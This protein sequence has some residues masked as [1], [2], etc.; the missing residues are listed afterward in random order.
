[1]SAADANEDKATRKRRREDP[2]VVQTRELVY[3][4]TVEVIAEVGAAGISVD[5]IAE[6]SGVARSTIYRHWP[7]QSKLYLEA[8]AVL[9]RRDAVPLTGE[10]RTDLENYLVEY[11]SRL[12]DRTYISVLI[13]LLDRV[14]RD[15]EFAELYRAIFDERRSRAASIFRNGVRKGEFRKGIDIAEAVVAFLAPFTY[16][17]IVRHEQI[18]PRHVQRV[19][20]DLFERFG[21]AE[22]S[23]SPKPPKPKRARAAAA[24]AT[25]RK[26]RVASS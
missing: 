12:N 20:D 13:A 2:R 16:L 8:F 25:P 6:A 18:K 21:T 9:A 15:Q 11:A 19:I 3:K 17:S 1:M 23:A 4:T 7:D 24:A 22:A 14:A 5:R 10:T 26:Q